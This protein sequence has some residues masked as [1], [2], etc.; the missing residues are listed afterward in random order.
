MVE[1]DIIEKNTH[2][3]DKFNLNVNSIMHGSKHY[4]ESKYG[5][6]MLPL[7]N[8]T[9]PWLTTTASTCITH[10]GLDSA[11]STAWWFFGAC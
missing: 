8:K 4:L 5:S 3:V 2:I 1:K 11:I 9:K 6:S 10:P 7:N